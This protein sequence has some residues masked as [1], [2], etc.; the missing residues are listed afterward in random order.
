LVLVIACVNVTNLL[1]ARGVQ[2]RGE[3]AV[4]AA[5]GAG[6]KRL[7]RQL[8]TESLVLAAVGGMFGVAIAA[9]GSRAL[10]ALSP[11]DLP[12]VGAISVDGSVFLFAL[13][14]TTVIGLAFGVTPALQAAGRDPREDLQQGS[15]RTAGGHRRAR[16]ML[17]V[18]EVA[19]ALVLLVSSGLLLRSI[20]RLFAVPVGFDPS[21]M[22]TMQVQESGHRYNTDSARYRFFAQSLEA[23]QRTPGVTAAAFTSQLPLSGDLDEYGAVF[24]ATPTQEAR[25]YP[26][27]RYAVSP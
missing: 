2:R 27:Y 12:R 19:L 9:L 8:L 1:L 20:Q 18:S 24:E 25:R 23:I 21:S 16:N 5:L 22:L 4:R 15:R 6:R 17:V 11:P 14:I 10:V 13:G 7:V 3:F 26:A